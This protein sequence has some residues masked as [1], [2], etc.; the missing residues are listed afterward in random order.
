MQVATPLYPPL[1]RG[2]AST[3]QITDFSRIGKYMPQT[4]S[5]CYEE[6]VPQTDS[7]C[8]SGYLPQTNSLCYRAA[9][10]FITHQKL[11]TPKPHNQ[12]DFSNPVHSIQAVPTYLPM[13]CLLFLGRCVPR[14]SL[15]EFHSRDGVQLCRLRPQI[16]TDSGC[17]RFS[18]H[19]QV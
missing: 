18:G 2:Q 8:Y 15:Q 1:S 13:R 14:L 9:L 12:H 11:Y 3:P 5:L 19:L 10:L 6:Y 16:G 7:L 17:N 4:N